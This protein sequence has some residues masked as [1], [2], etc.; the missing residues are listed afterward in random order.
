MPPVYAWR[1][2]SGPVNPSHTSGAAPPVHEA[3]GGHAV[4]PGYARPSYSRFYKKE[5]ILIPQLLHTC[6][7][8]KQAIT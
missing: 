1:N 3:T 2:R 8:I 4:R 7:W 5:H 6:S